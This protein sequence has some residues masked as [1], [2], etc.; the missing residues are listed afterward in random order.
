MK[1]LMLIAVLCSSIVF[2]DVVSGTLHRSDANLVDD[3]MEDN[4]IYDGRVK[5]ISLNGYVTYAVEFPGQYFSWDSE[6]D[7]NR[8]AA[9]FAAV[10][11]VSELTSWHSDF[12]TCL[13]EDETLVMFTEDCRTAVR[14]SEQGYSDNYLGTFMANTIL[15]GERSEV[16]P[17]FNF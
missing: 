6:S 13:F 5:I 16:D 7:I 8:M 3:L 1:V 14:L 2:G 9:V 15:V 12:A 17:A 10:G 11:V 4:G